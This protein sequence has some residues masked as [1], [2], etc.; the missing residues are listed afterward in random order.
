[1]CEDNVERRVQPYI[2]ARL[3]VRSSDVR[4]LDRNK[5]SAGRTRT[6][7]TLL[8]LIATDATQVGDVATATATAWHNGQTDT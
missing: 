1:M 6:T 2:P 4:S 8:T 5:E 7:I 3:K